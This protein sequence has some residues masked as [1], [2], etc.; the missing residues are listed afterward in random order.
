MTVLFLKQF[1]HPQATTVEVTTRVAGAIA[2]AMEVLT[3]A[4]DIAVT[5]SQEE[6]TIGQPLTTKEDTT[7][8]F[9]SILQYKTTGM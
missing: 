3:P 1:F 5:S 9:V 8:F 2:I 6:A 7:R 4:V